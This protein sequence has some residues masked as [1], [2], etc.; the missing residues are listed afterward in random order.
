MKKKPFKI[1]CRWNPEDPIVIG[2]EFDTT[3]WMTWKRYRTKEAMETAFKNLTDKATR[4]GNTAF[5]YR[6]QS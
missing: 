2:L 3:R 4:T 5:E 1:L 6:M